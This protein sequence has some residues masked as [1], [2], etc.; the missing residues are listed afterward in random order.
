MGDYYGI[1]A[2][3]TEGDLEHSEEQLKGSDQR[4][5]RLEQDDEPVGRVRAEASCLRRRQGG[6]VGVGRR[7]HRQPGCMDDPV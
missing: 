2:A 6:G 1:V 7:K 3:G 5:R 4:Q